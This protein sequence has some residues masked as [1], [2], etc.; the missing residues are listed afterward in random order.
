M[1][2]DCGLGALVQD[3][4]VRTSPPA[5]WNSL[6]MLLLASWGG[7]CAN[8]GVTTSD[9]GP[10]FV[11]TRVFVATDYSPGTDFTLVG[12]VRRGGSHGS[13]RRR[14]RFGRPC[15]PSRSQ[16]VS[17]PR[18]K[19]SSPNSSSGAAACTC[20]SA[21]YGSRSGT[22]RQTSRSAWT[23]AAKGSSAPKAKRV[24]TIAAWRTPASTAASPAVRRCTSR[25][26]MPFPRGTARCSPHDDSGRHPSRE[27]AH[28]P[29][30][31]CLER[32][33]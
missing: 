11:E 32:A 8:G 5:P 24:S 18:E 17:T 25:S 20:T 26:R 31:A 4:A 13:P 22:H 10:R 2:L 33:G 15:N 30:N 29:R 21:R 3:G 1:K 9:Q 19:R 27:P 12:L 7:G 6:L 16:L 23:R 14:T 28:R